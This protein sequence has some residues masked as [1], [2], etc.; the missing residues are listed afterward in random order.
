[1]TSVSTTPNGGLNPVSTGA[2]TTDLG[3][4]PTTAF[5]QNSTCIGAVCGTDWTRGWTALSRLGYT[6]GG[7]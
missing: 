7:A 1:M 6:A 4:A 3:P 5:F 2:A